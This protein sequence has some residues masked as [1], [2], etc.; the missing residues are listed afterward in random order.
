MGEFE[1]GL[2]VGLFITSGH[3]GGD[4]RRPHAIVKMHLRNEPLLRLLE[5]L[6]PGSK[7]YGPYRQGG[8]IFL[9]WVA[10]GKTLSSLLS[11][12]DSVDLRSISPHA[13]ERLQAM[14]ERYG[15]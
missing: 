8:R 13:F 2:I 4:G 3:F 15:V 14:R 10:R 11:A 5:R 7:V 9:Q 12:L 1:R 6:F